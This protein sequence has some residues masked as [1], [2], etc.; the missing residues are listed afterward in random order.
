MIHGFH[1][2]VNQIESLH[3]FIQGIISAF[4]PTNHDG[5][6]THGRLRDPIFE[7][8]NEKS[9]ALVHQVVQVRLCM[10]HF[11][12]HA[13]LKPNK[14]NVFSQP[15][16]P[17]KDNG[18]L[19]KITHRQPVIQYAMAMVAAVGLGSV[20]THHHLVPGPIFA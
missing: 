18:S 14:K 8:I 17:K 13:N 12:H 16:V 20:Q 7:L 11:C 9:N 3:D 6:L 5:A 4:S 10:G 15:P 19:K 2:M 1:D